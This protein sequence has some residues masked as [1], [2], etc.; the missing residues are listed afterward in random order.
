VRV[1]HTDDRAG[2]RS[3]SGGSE[4]VDGHRFHWGGFEL[5]NLSA[6]CR[7]ELGFWAP[8]IE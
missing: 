7:L 6:V 8:L 1:F 3:G 2:R 5:L 4:L